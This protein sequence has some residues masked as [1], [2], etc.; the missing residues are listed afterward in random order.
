M[1]NPRGES[2]E[3]PAGPA[4]RP[5]RCVALGLYGVIAAVI[6]ATALAVGA[7]W[8][9]S[10]EARLVDRTNQV[11]AELR[12][13]L[14]SMVD[15]ETAYRGFALSGDEEY[16]EPSRGAGGDFEAH[17]TRI[18]E[19][20]ADNPRQQESAENLR[21]LG[22]A[23]LS[24]L[25]DRVVARRAGGLEAVLPS[26]GTRFG[27]RKMDEIRVGVEE[28]EKEERVLLASRAGSAATARRT[29]AI[30]FAVLGVSLV[31]ALVAIHRFVRRELDRQ[32]ESR[33]EILGLNEDLRAQATRATAL[34]EERD[35][36]FTLSRDLVAVAG[37]DGFFKRLNPSWERV[38]GWKGEDL[39]RRPFLDFV[40]PEDRE[41]T[42]KEAAKIADGGEALEFVNRYRTFDGSW[43]WLE[44]KARLDRPG[45]DTVYAV[46]RDI[47]ERKRAEADLRA[48]K[49]ATEA[50]NRELESF[51]HTV[52]HDLRA[53]LRAI[54]G[55]TQ[56]ILQDAAGK[57]PLEAEAHFRRV[58][59][60]AAR[61][62]GLIDDLLRLSRIGRTEMT[63]DPVDLGAMAREIEADLRREDPA[64]Q[65]D[66]LL[67]ED[68]RTEGD[69]RLLR[70]ALENLLG[71]AW[72]FTSK[73]PRAAVEVGKAEVGG[74][75]AF[76]VKDN[77][78][79]FDPAY[80]SKLFGVF[81]RLHPSSEFPGTG[82]GLATV[83]RIVHRHGGRVWADGSPGR[84]ASFWFTLPAKGA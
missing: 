78:A 76:F 23:K 33:T 58:Q 9:E 28:M 55:F 35:R 65:V 71:N 8:W 79:G 59:S 53:P 62:G 83:A 39:L 67:M 69:P 46:A 49:A 18:R 73:L 2:A 64:R 66:L 37:T 72:K 12:S 48:A 17:L 45:G 60:A 5:E 36:V 1:G 74:G 81:Q 68:L 75:A 10:R 3:T 34:A 14:L 21:T 26:Y 29:T 44:W 63:R 15:A 54:H 7:V 50:A 52:S 24:F 25:E 30:A 31:G 42:V 38:L 84:G 19:L 47:T 77:G 4:S 41:A 51:T 43:R 56:A 57:L 22:R 80:A 70:V 11:L 16:L 40:H 13:A 27:K 82:V 20:T 32:E 6:L 61:M